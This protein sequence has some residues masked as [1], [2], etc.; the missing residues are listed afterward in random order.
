ML[1]DLGRFFEGAKVV[2]G[3]ELNR[4]TAGRCD[5][6]FIDAMKRN[7][8][9]TDDAE[10]AGVSTFDEFLH[11]PGILNRGITVFD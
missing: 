2:D 6:R 5:R 4:P 10:R 11:E 9:F 8:S 1:C 3:R 7:L